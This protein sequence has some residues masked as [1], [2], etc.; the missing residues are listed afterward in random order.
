MDISHFLSDKYTSFPL[1]QE[2]SPLLTQKSRINFNKSFIIYISHAWIH[3]MNP[4]DDDVYLASPTAS[5]R[6]PSSQSSTPSPTGNPSPF[7]PTPDTNTNEKYKLCKEALQ[8]LWDLLAKGL[9]CYIWIDCCCTNVIDRDTPIENIEE[10]IQLSDILFTPITGHEN[11]PLSPYGI[12]FL[13]DYPMKLWNRS[14][15]AYIN[16]DI[17]RWEMYL[18]SSLPISSHSS[19]KLPFLRASLPEMI[20]SKKRMHF[21]F[22][23]NM[24][25][26]HFLPVSLPISSKS[27]QS[28]LPK[29]CYSNRT[30]AVA[31]SAYFLSEK[32]KTARTLLQKQSCSDADGPRSTSDYSVPVHHFSLSQPETNDNPKKISRPPPLIAALQ[33]EFRTGDD[34]ERDFISGYHIRILENGDQYEGEWLD[35][36]MHGSGR[37]LTN[38]GSVITGTWNHDVLNDHGRYVSPLG[39]IYEGNWSNNHWHGIGVYKYYNGDVY[40]GEFRFGLRHGDGEFEYF[41]TG[42]VYSGQWKNNQRNGHG[43][44]TNNITGV[45]YE[46]DWYNGVLNGKGIYEKLGMERY[47]GEWKDG[48][49]NGY[50]VHTTYSHYNDTTG[51]GKN[52]SYRENKIREG[53][54]QMGEFI[55]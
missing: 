39:E 48:K 55:E 5:S 47:E 37:L 3:Y 54:W 36:K 11:I 22:D 14:K 25:R 26:Q 30:L 9:N 38:N 4:G 53:Y 42:D 35:G 1:Y 50:G 17:C 43:T 12:D 40:R 45:T 8:L 51:S 18:S 32:Q 20:R 24:Q 44:L 49:W 21:L 19:L 28:I 13:Q 34:N 29:A 33:T 41:A 46:G 6:S 15:Y 2:N 31:S 52:K 10:I 16:R 27:Y 23:S 7:L